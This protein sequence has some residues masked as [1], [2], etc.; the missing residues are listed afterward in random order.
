MHATAAASHRA[1]MYA[2]LLEDDSSESSLR[3]MHHVR[4]IRHVPS[5]VPK[6]GVG[7]SEAKGTT[8]SF[9]NHI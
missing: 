6:Q 3:T 2:D 1:I 5:G 7:Y 4:Q 8:F 9:F